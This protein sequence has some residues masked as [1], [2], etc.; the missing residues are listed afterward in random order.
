[1]K[2]FQFH[3]FF[4]NFFFLNLQ[5]SSSEVEPTVAVVFEPWH[6]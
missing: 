4:L 5:Q 3:N 2:E 6:G 1:M